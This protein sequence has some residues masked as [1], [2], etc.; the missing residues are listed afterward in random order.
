MKLVHYHSPSEL[1]RDAERWDDLWRRSDATLPVLKAELLAQWVEHF[2]PRRRF[3]AAAVESEGRLLAALPIVGAG[4]LLG[5]VPGNCW[6]AAGDLLVD[7]AADHAAVLQTL[8]GGLAKTRWPVIMADGVR[9]ESR[10]WRS[11]RAALAGRGLRSTARKQFYVGQIDVSGGWD[12][13]EASWSGNHRR[14]MRKSL[15]KLRE[16]GEVVL[17]RHIDL[18]PDQASDALSTLCALEDRSWKGG[19]GTSILRTP[20]MFAYFDRQTRRLAETGELE[21]LFVEVAGRPVA[22]DYGYFGKGVFHSHKIAFDPEFRH[23]GPGQLLCYLQLQLYFSHSSYH[24]I[25][26]LG[27]LSEANAKWATRAYAVSRVVMSTNRGAGN[28]AVLGYERVWP[29][30]K[31]LLK[32]SDAVPGLENLAELKTPQS[33]EQENEEESLAAVR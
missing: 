19:Q 28:A 11:L 6:S 29:S 33:A 9:A 12:A 18:S 26:T 27:I 15:R 3:W 17:R 21:M 10:R 32:R 7:A 20:G 4:P 13:Y 31:K 30:L 22:A 5:V 8:A 14:A 16:S 25:D 23:A 1:R 24:T 2:A